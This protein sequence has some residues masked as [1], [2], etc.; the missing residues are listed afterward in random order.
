ME[1]SLNGKMLVD[2]EEKGKPS[3]WITLRAL[4][5]L[6]RAGVEGI[7]YGAPTLETG[8]DEDGRSNRIDTDCR[9]NRYAKKETFYAILQAKGRA[10]YADY[11]FHLI[12]LHTHSWGVLLWSYPGKP[13]PFVDENGN[14]L[15]GSIS[16]KVFVNINGVE[17]GMFIKSKDATHPVLLY[18]HGGY[19]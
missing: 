8:R 17:Q 18:L 1:R 9:R 7:D 19:A 11:N 14:P 10:Y 13:K 12:G 15:A 6:K 16:E 5:V 4:R 3:K 2:I